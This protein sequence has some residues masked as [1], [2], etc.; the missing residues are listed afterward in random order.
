[1]SKNEAHF[2]FVRFFF[3]FNITEYYHNFV[4]FYPNMLTGTGMA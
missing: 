2:F 1:M 4:L 3:F